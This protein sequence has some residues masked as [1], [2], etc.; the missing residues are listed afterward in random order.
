LPN[1]P[2]ATGKNAAVLKHWGGD[3]F[4]VRL[5]IDADRAN[6][7]G[8]T[9]QDVATASAAGLNGFTVATLREGDEQIPVMARLRMEERARLSDI[10]SLYVY[11]SQGRQKVPLGLVSSISY[12]TQTEKIV[13]RKQFRTVTVSAFPVENVLSSEVLNAAMPQ[14]R[15][16][17]KR[18]PPGYLMEIGGEYEEQT[19]GFRNLAIVMG[20]S[21]AMIFLALVIQFRHAVKPFIVFAAIPYGMVGATVIALF[22]LAAHGGPLWEPMCYAQIGGLTAATFITLILVRVIYSIF[23]FDLKLV[24]WNSE[25]HRE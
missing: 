13:R 23:V 17:E 20:I 8:V 12:G 16:F 6:L 2:E 14:V 25:S 11:S 4:A 7:A 18:L 1:T 21:V 24:W 10:Q 9:N 3:S 5:A 22:P 15:A 19:K